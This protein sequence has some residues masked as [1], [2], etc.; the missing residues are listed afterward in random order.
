MRRVTGERRCFSGPSCSQSE[1]ANAKSM[2]VHKLS[3]SGLAQM[4]DETSEPTEPRDEEVLVEL[5]VRFEIT[6][7][8]ASPCD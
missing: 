3:K 5:S 1:R 4:C 7:A 6:G 8:S 2:Q